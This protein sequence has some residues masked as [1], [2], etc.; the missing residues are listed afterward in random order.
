MT[1]CAM[2]W[3]TLTALKPMGT[4]KRL[5]AAAQ[6]PLEQSFCPAGVRELA[7]AAAGAADGSGHAAV[8]AAARLPSRA[9]SHGGAC[10]RAHRCRNP[11]DACQFSRPSA[12]TSLCTLE[13]AIGLCLS[14]G[15]CSLTQP[16]SCSGSPT[17]EGT[18]KHIVS[19]LQV[20]YKPDPKMHC[21]RTRP[22][23]ADLP[24][25]T[26]AEATDLNKSATAAAADAKIKVRHAGDPVL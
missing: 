8:R 18:L 14:D 13:P 1:K 21:R 10:R 23:A 12:S 5:S 11:D 16:A 6:A 3:Q 4:A 9:Q 15:D 17:M 24:R 19:C 25:P 7:E 26:D 20:L 22:S 2:Q